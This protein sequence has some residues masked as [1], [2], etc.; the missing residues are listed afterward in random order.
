MVCSCI[1]PPLSTLCC[2]SA[3]NYGHG[4]L[5]C[6]G[7]E[8]IRCALISYHWLPVRSVSFLPL[9]SCHHLFLRSVC[10]L[11]H[12]CDDPAL[13]RWPSCTRGS[14]FGHKHESCL[15]RDACFESVLLASVCTLGL[16]RY[17]QAGSLGVT[18]PTGSRSAIAR[19][20]VS[21]PGDGSCDS[22]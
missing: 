22:L 4:H 18:E 2:C 9:S 8:P 1:P 11:V 13:C 15:F 17:T 20:S 21:N 16:I 7:H 19:G 12:S 14:S 6:Y 5:C 3:S 10:V